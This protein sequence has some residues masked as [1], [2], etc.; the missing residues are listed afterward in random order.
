MFTSFKLDIYCVSYF[1]FQFIC[2]NDKIGEEFD[3]EGRR[4]RLFVGVFLARL[5]I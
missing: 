4:R 1:V 3:K 5:D 2:N